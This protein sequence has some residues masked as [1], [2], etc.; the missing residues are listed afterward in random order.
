MK[1]GFETEAARSLYLGSGL[2]Q[3]SIDR[4]LLRSVPH[5]QSG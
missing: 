4:L 3:T 2:V 5:E 1:V